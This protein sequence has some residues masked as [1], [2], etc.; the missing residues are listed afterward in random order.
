MIISVASVFIEINK[1][2]YK[3]KY[4]DDEVKRNI[5]TV[6]ERIT[7]VINKYTNNE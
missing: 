2:T 5:D 3:N 7:K 1:L 6:F 4:L